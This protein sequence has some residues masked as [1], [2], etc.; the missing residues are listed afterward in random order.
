MIIV[1]IL[2]KIFYSFSFC[3]ALDKYPV[4]CS[5][6]YFFQSKW[7]LLYDLCLSL[8]YF[9]FFMY[10]CLICMR[11]S[12]KIEIFFFL[13]RSVKMYEELLLCIFLLIVEKKIME[14]KPKDVSH[15]HNTH[16][17]QV[18]SFQQYFSYNLRFVVNC[19]WSHSFIGTSK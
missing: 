14:S 6:S 5:L 10:L 17:S 12:W 15:T 16:R 2:F 13:L 4:A 19:R 9:W 11:F 18:S 1:I 8:F 3:V 7:I